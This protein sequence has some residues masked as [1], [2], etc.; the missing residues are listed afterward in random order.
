MKWLAPVLLL[1]CSCCYLGKFVV[2]PDPNKNYFMYDNDHRICIYHGVNVSNYSKHS[3][4]NFPWQTNA[5]FDRLN[6]WGFNVV[7]YLVFWSAIEP[8]R[9]T[10]DTLY[11]NKTLDHIQYLTSIG[12]SVIIDIHQDLYADTFTGNG[13]PD[14]TVRDD[15]IPFGGRQEPWNLTYLDKAVITSYNNFWHNNTLKNL[16]VK[17]VD[18]L[19]RSFG[20]VPGVLGIDVMNEPIPDLS[21]KFERKTLTKFYKDIEEVFKNSKLLM[22]YEPWMSTSAGLPTCLKFY[23]ETKAVYYPHYYDLIVDAKKPYGEISKVIMNKVV[24]TKVAEAQKFRVPI[25]FGE[26]GMSSA[27]TGSFNFDYLKDL[28]NLF[29][30]HSAGWTYWSFDP[31][32]YNDY[33]IVDD[34]GNDKPVLGVLVRIYPQKIAGMNPKWACGDHE[35]VLEYGSLQKDGITELFIPKNMQIAVETEGTWAQDG[36]KLIY[37]NTEHYSQIIKIRH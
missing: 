13:F 7:R 9:G 8:Q 20:N 33:G 29:D 10:Y 3:D 15:G 19:I 28:L 22:F 24:P 5:D 16:Y 27:D 2:E 11:I 18:F 35:F 12:V 17:M 6:E 14:W 30:Q 26:F 1:F 34:N 37:K 21:G 31:N 32:M 4:H 25:M 36:Q 23:P